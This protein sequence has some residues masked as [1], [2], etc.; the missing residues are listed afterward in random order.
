MIIIAIELNNFGSFQ[1]SRVEL[2]PGLNLI[3]GAN[4]SGKST[5][6]SALKTAF[7]GERKGYERWKNWG[8]ANPSCVVTVE[9]ELPDKTVWSLVRDLAKGEVSLVQLQGG[10]VQAKGPTKVQGLVGRHL[11]LDKAETFLNTVFVRAGELA[12][13]LVGI[14][15]ALRA[16][17]E[18]LLVGSAG[19]SITKAQKVL[20]EKYKR[21]AGT[22]AQKGEGGQI[23]ALLAQEVD[24]RR[25]MAQAEQI[26]SQRDQWAAEL[27]E[28]QELL[29]KKTARLK[30][31]KELIDAVQA[32]RVLEVELDKLSDG[33]KKLRMKI[34]R[35]KADRE[36]LGEINK[37]MEHLDNYKE[38][39][40]V[41]AAA[42]K[43]KAEILKEKQIKMGVA[44]DDGRA[45]AETKKKYAI[46]AFVPAVA[47]LLVGIILVVLSQVFLGVAA[48]ILGLVGAAAGLKLL[49]SRTS[50][51]EDLESYL[52][53]EVERLTGEINEELSKVG[54]AGLESFLAQQNKC[55]SLAKEL[56]NIEYAD[57]IMLEGSSLEELSK[58]FDNL[59]DQTH[60]LELQ[61]KK[62]T[63]ADL[64]TEE[65]FTHE[66]EVSYL[67]P[68]VASLRQTHDTLIGRLS[69]HTEISGR[70]I[71]DLLSELNYIS[72]QLEGSKRHA[73]ALSLAAQEILEIA[74]EISGEVAPQI[75]GA[76]SELLSALTGG[77]HSK[78]GLEGNLTLTVLDKEVTISPDAL[79]TATADQLYFAVRLAAADLIS[80]EAKPP[81][82]LD[83]PLVYFDDDR[84]KAARD[85]VLKLAATRQIIF[86]SHN[87]SFKDWPGN[88]IEL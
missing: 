25:E 69:S 36:R 83:D 22:I 67:S 21:L 40:A 58:E 63:K 31:V 16:R 59:F 77:R 17:V 79:S 87:N 4:E 82:I 38:I 52:K 9:Y 32:R 23:G 60:S 64:S 73:K 45:E 66:R 70:S 12:P 49:K 3:I 2:N 20:K 85:I 46:F 65:I 88:L 26:K 1:E 7:F 18:S 43:H 80:G 42:L 30:L 54:A 51:A 47:A 68:E 76:A 41:D 81:L 27:E 57:S 24:S 29:V 72:D 75:A 39:S 78:V 44:A 55:E 8:N 50:T 56:G 33:R 15:P 71:V 11:G 35:L 10:E 34:E 84:F 6:Q 86:F 14:E 61:L 28:T 13:D 53:E 5:I 62:A 48:I 74:A 37:E 19:G